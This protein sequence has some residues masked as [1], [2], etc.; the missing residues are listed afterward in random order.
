MQKI[1]AAFD[2]LKYSLSTQQHAIEIAK[3][4][5]VHLVG[6]FLDDFTYHSYK[7][8]E[9]AGPDMLV[10]DAIK[11][12]NDKDE[13]VRT[14]SVSKFSLACQQAGVNYAVHRDKN[15]ALQ[16]LLH[17]SVYADLLVI[18]GGETFSHYVKPMPTEFIR[19]VLTDVQCPVLVTTTVHKPVEKLYFLYDGEPSSVYAIKM[20]DYLMHLYRHLPAEVI[21]VRRKKDSMHVLDNRLMKEF[22]KR[23]FPNAEYTVLKGEP[24]EVVVNYLSDQRSSALV[25]LGTYQRSTVSRWFSPSLADYLIK[26][27]RLPFFIAHK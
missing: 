9:V 27:L 3:M 12:L 4:N 25:V 22:M 14:A 6:V 10:D 1:I 19:D 24:E 15:L 2:G 7:V 21:S 11:E 5:N 26:E 18:N 17:E 8:Y 13:E 16:E 20:F 23:H